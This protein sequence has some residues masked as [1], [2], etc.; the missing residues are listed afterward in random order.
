MRRLFRPKSG[1]DTIDGVSPVPQKGGGMSSILP[2]PDIAKRRHHASVTPFPIDAGRPAAPGDGSALPPPPPPPPLQQ[3]QQQ[4][5]QALPHP[6]PAMR[7]GRPPPPVPDRSATPSDA[8][9]IAA[10]Y[11]RDAGDRAGYPAHSRVGAPNDTWGNVAPAPAPPGSM[12][13][14]PETQYYGQSQQPSPVTQPPP[15]FYLPP[16]A[17][18]PDPQQQQFRPSTPT[19]LGH[20]QTPSMG[21]AGSLPVAGYSTDLDGGYASARSRG[22]SSASQSGRGSDHEGSVHHQ[23]APQLNKPTPLPPSSRSP[24]VNAFPEPQPTVA[25]GSYPIAPPPP[26]HAYNQ[27]SKAQPPPPPPPNGPP[28]DRAL[29]RPESD[30]LLPAKADK[31]DKGDKKRFWNVGW[32]PKSSKAKEFKDV[33][34]SAMEPPPP[35]RRSH[36]GNRPSFDDWRDADISNHGHGSSLGHSLEDTQRAKLRPFEPVRQT[37]QEAADEVATGIRILCAS[38]ETTYTNVVHLCDQVNN[39]EYPEAVSKEMAR[40]IRRQLKQGADP[41]RR[42]AARVWLI[43]MRCITTGVYRPYATNRKFLSVIESILL[44]HAKLPPSKK[45][46]DTIMDIVS[47]LT[48]QFGRERGCEGLV[49]LW[50]KVK[51]PHEPEEGRALPDDYLQ[52]GAAN[53]PAA[54]INHPRPPPIIATGPSPLPSPPPSVPVSRPS[55]QPSLQRLSLI[56]RY[57]AGQVVQSPAAYGGGP[58]YHHLPDHKDDM[59][60][61][62]EECTA[63]KESARVLAEAVVFTQPAE[64]QHKPIIKEF[65]RKTFLAHESLTNQMDWAQAEAAKARREAESVENPQE[66]Q[67]HTTL[68]EVALAQLFEAHSVVA[69]ALK[70]YDDLERM[71]ADEQEMRAVQERSKKETRLDRRQQMDMLAPGESAEA[72]ASRSPSPHSTPLGGAGGSRASPPVLNDRPLPAAAPLHRQ[73]GESPTNQILLHAVRDGGRSR[74]PSPDRRGLP[75]PPKVP[76]SPARNPSPV[77]RSRIPGPRPLPSTRQLRSNNS[78]STNSLTGLVDGPHQPSRGGSGSTNNGTNGSGSGAEGDAEEDDETSAAAPPARPSRKALGKRRAEPVDPDNDFSPDD[79]F[80]VKKPET[81]DDDAAT[82]EIKLPSKPVKYAYDAYQE[83]LD[84]EAAESVSN[85]NGNGSGSG[86]A[87]APVAPA[88]SAR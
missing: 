68:E 12:P 54:P 19:R 6:P 40:S 84:R 31:H 7:L 9:L 5:Q 39:S 82:T 13:E 41:E 43:T 22:Y 11:R 30:N 45:T 27:W 42:M 71:A 17:G 87:S 44:H 14:P 4:Q 58:G 49:D 56:D 20:L 75:E 26:P 72:S 1:V 37:A 2:Q 50:H 15:H 38:H 8:E 55:S 64:L 24:L 21:T 35:I 83:K 46:Y 51:P 69:D 81:N 10:S 80:A 65:Y 29:L 3:Q 59:R 23:P 34:P 85:S 28:S 47:G 53:N 32:G 70:Q 25:P 33:P 67:H 78:P 16:G 73:L 63:A 66:Q 79:L 61:L 18:P 77:G 76:P 74:T 60:R 88:V 62:M 57:G 48:N 36:E 86:L 52:A